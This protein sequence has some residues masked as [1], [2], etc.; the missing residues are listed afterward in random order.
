MSWLSG[1]FGK[2]KREKEL[3]E[4]V[5][6]HLEMAARE[7]AERGEKEEEAE[8]AARREFGNVGLVKEATRDAW[9]G[10]WLRDVVDDVRFGLRMLGK[11]P[12]F[13]S[14]AVLTLALG[15]G[16]NTTIFSVMNATLLRAL[17][18]P[19][20]DSLVL[21]WETFGKGPNHTIIVAAPNFWD[22]KRQ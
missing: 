10:K 5:R 7:C 3:E 1:L 15:I 13:T 4:E 11:N 16:A 6:S 12:A 9:G 8:H 20:P 19:N 21:V 17:P 2:Q 22:F 18:F 14:I